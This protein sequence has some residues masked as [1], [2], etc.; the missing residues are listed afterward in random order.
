MRDGEQDILIFPMWLARL[1]LCAFMALAMVAPGFAETPEVGAKNLRLEFLKLKLE[2]VKQEQA[3][4]IAAHDAWMNSQ[5]SGAQVP[6][7]VR[8][9]LRTGREDW[10]NSLR[11]IWRLSSEIYPNDAGPALMTSPD[12]GL[13]EQERAAHRSAAMP[14]IAELV[15]RIEGEIAALQTELGHK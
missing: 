4:A 3:K 6:M 15:K 12:S 9:S 7:G 14:E 5:Q 2:V 13:T 8:S 10:A 1:L 11:E